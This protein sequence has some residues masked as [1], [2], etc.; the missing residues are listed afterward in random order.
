MQ[1]GQMPGRRS[2]G[3][4]YL[5]TWAPSSP[6]T[7]NRPKPVSN[8]FWIF[9]F[10]LPVN[11]QRWGDVQNLRFTLLRGGVVEPQTDHSRY[12]P[13]RTEPRPQYSWKM[14]S[15]RA[16]PRRIQTQLSAPTPARPT[17]SVEEWESRAPLLDSAM[18]S[19]NAIKAASENR[20]LPP[21]VRPR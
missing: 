19:I 9:V 10:S 5:R 2:V 3:L 8:G 15:T 6:P 11:L 17:I 16:P 14:T 18:K 12:L 13:L 20:P 7:A 4:G 1:R 21:K